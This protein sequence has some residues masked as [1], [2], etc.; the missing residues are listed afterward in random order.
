ML[1]KIIFG[2]LSGTVGCLVAIIQGIFYI[3]CF[4]L[5]F[6]MLCEIHFWTFLSWGILWITLLIAIIVMAYKFSYNALV[7]EKERREDITKEKIDK[8]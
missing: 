2:T 1:F 7:K 5:L 8:D 4:I 3:A 6:Q